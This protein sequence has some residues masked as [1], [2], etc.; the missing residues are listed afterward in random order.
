MRS[1]DFRHL[2]DNV[3]SEEVSLLYFVKFVSLVCVSMLKKKTISKKLNPGMS[4]VSSN[5]KKEIP[6]KKQI[7][8]G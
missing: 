6:A 8:A 1:T 2:R 5:I 7:W 3:C 4:I